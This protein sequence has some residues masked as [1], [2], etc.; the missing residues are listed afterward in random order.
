MSFSGGVFNINTTGQ[1][2]VNGTVISASV[3]N[4]LTADLA[5]GLSTCLLKDGTQTVTANIPMSSFKFTGL[6]AGSTA[7]DSLRYEQLYSAAI[8]PASINFGQTTLSN[9]TEGTWTP[10]LGGNT[11]YAN[12]A[13]RYTRIGRLVF[14]SYRVDVTTLGT[15]SAS[16]ISGLPFATGDDLSG[17]S[18]AYFTG[19][20]RSVTSLVCSSSSSSVIFSDLTAAATG[21]NFNTSIFQNGAG[22]RGSVT[23]QV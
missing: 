19:I 16:T 21:I 1:P 7:G 4:A 8:T 14:A 22:V 3:F 18:V 9:Y 5:T 11:T 15:G 2:V 17:G 6:A 23:Y 12:Q 10:S 20:A 13:G